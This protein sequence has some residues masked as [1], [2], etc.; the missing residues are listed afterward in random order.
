MTSTPRRSNQTLNSEDWPEIFRQ[1]VVLHV[2]LVNAVAPGTPIRSLIASVPPSIMIAAKS[3][4]AF[5]RQL[6]RET[7]AILLTFGFH[8]LNG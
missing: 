3:G 2:F 8:S 6:L 4:D 5:S 7:V 1:R